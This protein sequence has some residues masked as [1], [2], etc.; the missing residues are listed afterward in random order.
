G[1]FLWLLAWPSRLAV[2]HAFSPELP[3]SSPE[4]LRALLLVL[5]LGALAWTLWRKRA[6]VAC[7]AALFVPAAVA[8]VLLRVRS[9]GLFP[10]SER[11]LYLAVGAFALL[12][13]IGCLQKLPT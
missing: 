10:L 4:Y 6:D 7:F 1:G 13:S 2:F 11:Y 8:P 5:A 12:V 9:L 3:F